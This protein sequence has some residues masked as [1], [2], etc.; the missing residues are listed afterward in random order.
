MNKLFTKIAGVTLGFAM[1]IGVG[2]AVAGNK[3]VTLVKADADTTVTFSSLGLTNGVQYTTLDHSTHSSI[4]NGLSFEFGNG[5]NDG[6][7]Y[8]TGAAIRVYG[9]GHMTVAHASKTF[10]AITLTFGSGDGSNAITTSPAT[11][12][13][14]TWTGSANSVTFNVGGASGH[15]RIASVAVTYEG[16]QP[17]EKSISVDSPVEINYS[18]STKTATLSVKKN[19]GATGTVTWTLKSGSCITFPEENT[20][21]SIVVT[22]TGT[23]TAVVTATCSDC[24]DPVDVTVNVVAI[25]HAGTLADPFTPKDAILK[26]QIVGSTATEELYYVRGLVKDYNW[27]SS[28]YYQFVDVVNDAGSSE[29]FRFYGFNAGPNYAKFKQA[30][31]ITKGT[32]VITGIGHI[33]NYSDVTPEFSSG[34]YIY[35]KVPT[36]SL[37]VTGISG[38]FNVGDEPTIADLGVTV[39][40]TYDDGTTADVTSSATITGGTPLANKGDNTITFSYSEEHPYSGVATVVTGTATL[41]DVI[42]PVTDV[43]ITSDVSQVNVGETITITAEALPANANNKTLTWSSNA[44]DVAT[45]DASTGVVTGVAAGSARITATSNNNVSAFVDVLVK[46]PTD[47]PT[48]LELSGTLAKDAY[49]VN[50]DFDPTGLTATLTMAKSGTVDVTNGVTWDPAKLTTAGENI[51]VTASYT[52]GTV[53]VSDS[54]NVRVVNREIDHFT[55]T[56][57][58]KLIYTQADTALDLDGMNAKAY[59]TLGDYVDITNDVEL[60]AVDFTSATKQTVTVTYNEQTVG[61]FEVTVN[62]LHCPLT[63]GQKYVLA[64]YADNGEKQEYFEFKE[65]STTATVYGLGT[66]YTSKYPLANSMVFIA[67]Q[68]VVDNSVALKVVVEDTNYY[69]TWLSGNSLI[70]NAELNENSSWTISTDSTTTTG[71]T[72]SLLTNVFDVTRTVFWNI[73]NPRFAAYAGKTIGTQYGGTMIYEYEY[74]K[75]GNFVEDYMHPEIALD[76]KGTAPYETCKGTGYYDVAKPAFNALPL[77]VRTKLAEDEFAFHPYYERLLAWAKAN[78]DELNSSH[79]LA[80]G[81][82]GAFN[83]EDSNDVATIVVIIAIAS[84]SAFGCLLI[85]KKRKHQ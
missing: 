10:S 11:W 76:D 42:Q 79:L 44:T 31:L 41:T 61:T 37:T 24:A 17:E 12:A 22:A 14:P 23:G 62:E 43:N 57:P 77:E 9:G 38:S 82:R 66:Q 19:G 74:C 2:V 75:A 8:N 20:G 71:I 34:C 52:L 26:A 27:Y 58:T 84:I 80:S 47:I 16:G 53:T 35:S 36:G 81:A 85:L 64:A 59:Y 3:K 15:R 30:S 70:L 60:S 28:G 67:T 39:T 46:D 56:A 49:Y 25:E 32:S 29:I 63:K 55:F 1:A 5:G 21:D 18:S 51:E 13:S 40:A 72:Y 48:K 68:G 73:T 83:S 45:V 54:V 33:V 7:Y 6:K 78:G 50:E 69:L 4:E 65:F